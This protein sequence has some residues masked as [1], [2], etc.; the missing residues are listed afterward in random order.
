MLLMQ[1][2]NGLSCIYLSLHEVLQTSLEGLLLATERPKLM[3]RWGPNDVAGNDN[4][5][6]SGLICNE[7]ADVKAPILQSG[8]V[9]YSTG[10][11]C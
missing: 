1:T 6:V 4:V 11:W 7:V 9:N 5:V 8:I 10:V 3:A 2:M